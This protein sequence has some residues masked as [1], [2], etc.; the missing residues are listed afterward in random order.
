MFSS[1]GG[2]PVVV[3]D[4]LDECGDG[5]MLARLMKLVLLLDKLPQH[6]MILVSARP[7]LEIRGAFRTS[8]YIPCVYTDKIS[9]DDTDH[10]IREMVRMD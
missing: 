6:F 1:A 5:E 2:F 9:N 7:E 4:G 3:L 10:T 8:R